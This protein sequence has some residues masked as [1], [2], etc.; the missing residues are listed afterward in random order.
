[1]INALQENSGSFALLS[2]TA[3]RDARGENTMKPLSR[4]LL[5]ICIF[6]LIGIVVGLS[7]WSIPAPQKEIRKSIS[8]DTFLT[9]KN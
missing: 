3:R 2:Y 9:R 6:T 1:L 8:V 4:V 7:M 5:G